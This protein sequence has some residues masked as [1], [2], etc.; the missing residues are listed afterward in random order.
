MESA[1]LQAKSGNDLKLILQLARKLGITAKKLTE[2]EL[3]DLGLSFAIAEG[4]TGEYMDT[5]E[6][7][8]ELLHGG[9][10]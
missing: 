3:E 2:T 8:N 9:K 6:F 7:L 10:D 5:D 4:S 1:I